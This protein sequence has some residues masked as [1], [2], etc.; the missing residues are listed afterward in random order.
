MDNGLFAVSRN[1]R[2]FLGRNRNEWKIK[3]KAGIDAFIFYEK[4][5]WKMEDVN[6]KIKRF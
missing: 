1:G 4:L 6:M 2:K 5:K 3:E